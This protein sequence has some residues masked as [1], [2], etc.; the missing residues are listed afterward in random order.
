MPV[1][2]VGVCVQNFRGCAGRTGQR[3]RNS[4]LLKEYTDASFHCEVHVSW[5]T[6]GLTN[7][8]D[9]SSSLPMGA[10][11]CNRRLPH[12]A[13]AADMY[14]PVLDWASRL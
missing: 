10:E 11:D 9:Q 3:A 2:F 4:L 14:L 7:Q 5:L 1:L 6:T 12:A 8:L 13:A